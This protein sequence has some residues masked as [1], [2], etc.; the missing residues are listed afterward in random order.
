MSNPIRV[1]ARVVH[2][3]EY[4]SRPIDGSGFR[5]FKIPA[6]GYMFETQR[7]GQ[8]PIYISMSDL[9]KLFVNPDMDNGLPVEIDS[10]RTEE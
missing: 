10:W 1:T 8:M 9:D 3:G 5:P 2:M 6:T 4:A 7:P